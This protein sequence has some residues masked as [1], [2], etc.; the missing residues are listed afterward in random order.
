[1]LPNLDGH[2]IC[3]RLKR[4]RPTTVSVLMVGQSFLKSAWHRMDLQA[5]YILPKPFPK[6]GIDH[7]ISKIATAA[8]R[9]RGLPH[10]YG[11]ESRP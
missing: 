10:V 7:A 9:C 6:T 2:E 11:S 3:R 8:L 1:M 5:R 4:H